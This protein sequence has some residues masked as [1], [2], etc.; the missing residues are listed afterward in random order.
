M[1]LAATA[2]GICVLGLAVNA[3]AQDNRSLTNSE[4]EAPRVETGGNSG[5]VDSNGGDES[6]APVEERIVLLQNTV[7]QLTQSL[8]NANAEA[9]TYKRQ[10]ADVTLKLQ[11]L[12][13]PGIEGDESKLEQRLLAAVRDLRLAKKDN[14]E[15]RTELIQL[16]EAVMALLK[17]SENITPEARSAVEIELRRVSE[18]LGSPNGA[19]A[20]K[21]ADATLND[22]LVVEV[23]DDLSLIVA[24][25]GEKQGVKIGMPFQV[26][27][28][29]KRIGQARVIDVRE[30]I[31]GAVI[32]NLENNKNPVKAGDQLRVDARRNDT[33][34]NN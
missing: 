14:E 10:A 21:A 15:F 31:S 30:R 12:G 8:A 3:G 13:L 5:R 19:A 32:Q 17:T 33:D 11:A 27:R 22:A 20:G 23:R 6:D 28:D 29:G 25:I 1:K 2:A 9:E 7:K 18:L 24:N 34:R 26:W 4:V 16:S